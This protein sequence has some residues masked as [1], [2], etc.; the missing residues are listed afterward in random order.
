MLRPGPRTVFV[1]KWPRTTRTSSVTVTDWCN[2]GCV[3]VQMRREMELIDERRR[4]ELERALAERSHRH[5]SS[6]RDVTPTWRHSRPVFYPGT[7]GGFSQNPRVQNPPKAQWIYSWLEWCFKIMFTKWIRPK[8]QFLIEQ[9]IQRVFWCL[10][11]LI[12][13]IEKL[14][15]T[16][17]CI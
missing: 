16:P 2:S 5:T 10:Y 11:V 3:D 8:E 4:A 13:Y 6:W 17:S 15:V 12:I 14:S 7:L 9:K 1:P